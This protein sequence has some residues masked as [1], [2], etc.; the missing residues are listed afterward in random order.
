[1][2]NCTRFSARASLGAVGLYLRKMRIWAAVERRVRIRQKV[3]K[4]TPTDKVLD[5]L[6]NILAGGQ[7]LVE[8]NTRVRPDEPLQRAFGRRACADQSS[9]SE[10][11]NACTEENVSQMRRALAEINRAHGQGYRHDYRRSWQLLDA[12]MTGLPAGRQGQGVSKGY[13]SG[14]KNRRGRQLGRVVAT[15]YDEI[16]IERLYTGKTQLE[17]SL[18][19]LVT[20]AEEVLELNRGQR[21]R[22]IVR[23]D[24]GGGRD[25]D[26][27][28]LLERGYH[29]LIKVKNWKRAAKL[30]ASVDAWHLDPK[31]GDRW[32]GW[33]RSPHPYVRPTRQLAVRT[34]KDDGTWRYVV[35]AFSLSD[36]QLLWM[37][38][39]PASRDPTPTAIL[40]AAVYAYDLRSG[41][42]E[43]SIRGS[44]SGL[45]LAKRN[46][47]RF[48][49]QEMLALLAQL[50]YNVLTW[51]RTLLATGA[52]KL[53]RFGP[54]RMVRDL[55]HIP[56]P[57]VLDAQGEVVSI[58]LNQAHALAEPFV[59]GLSPLLARD[60][61]A[62][63]LGQI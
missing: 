57:I 12:D 9:I 15:L 2:D 27:N 54:L 52:P 37:A 34:R 1:M 23:V 42:V 62:L 4:H 13:F 6:I 48:D 17:R 10:T 63:N 46:K 33:V 56:G 7:G 49:A 30:A 59:R 24:G 14:S 20:A 18:Q 31:T 22:T 55:F 41:G 35:L 3:V 58:T 8:V 36:A 19:A 29:V 32:I 50:A 21:E 25:E 45:G 61:M 16:V 5:A 60:G 11:L 51:T 44:K 39:R 38:R 28:W 43:T 26:V 47:R 40:F 53:R